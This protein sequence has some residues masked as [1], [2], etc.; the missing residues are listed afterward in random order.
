MKPVT[1]ERVDTPMGG[2][3]RIE[4]ALP[5]ASM[6]K[7]LLHPAGP[8]DTL[9]APSAVC[10][11]VQACAEPARAVHFLLSA[12]KLLLAQVLLDVHSCKESF[13]FP[14]TTCAYIYEQ[15]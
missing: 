8:L 12:S 2:R 15:L 14:L 13:M 9:F 11:G 4:T 7:R 6:I 5:C 3:P 1:T 10:V